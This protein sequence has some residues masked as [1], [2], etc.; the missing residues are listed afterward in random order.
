MSWIGICCPLGGPLLPSLDVPEDSLS[1]PSV[2]SGVIV[3]PP[4]V[5]DDDDDVGS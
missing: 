5:A 4:G 1:P 3:S 2:D